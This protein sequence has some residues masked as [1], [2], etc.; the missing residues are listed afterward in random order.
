MLIART[1]GRLESATDLRERGVW[2]ISD[3]E[4]HVAIRLKQ[5]FPKVP[6]HSAGPFDLPRDNVTAADLWWFTQRYPLAVTDEDWALIEAGRDAYNQIQ[7]ELERILMP[8]YQPPAIIGLK[9]G[10]KLRPYQ[11]AAVE[12]ARA[13]KFL[14]IGDE[15]GLGKTWQAL[16]LL[17]SEPGALPAAI[18]CDPHMQIQWERVTQEITYLRAHRITQAR[19]YDLPEADVYIFRVSQ[20]MGWTDIFAQGFFKAVVF[21]EPQS[22]RTGTA[23]A[24]GS[25]AKVL[26]DHAAYR[27]GLTATPI[28][29]YGR[30]MWHVLQFIDES[31][32]GDWDDFNREWCDVTGR[33]R[34]PKALG[35]YLREQYVLVRRLKSDVGLQLPQVSRIVEPIDYDAKA[36]KSVE[37]LAARLAIKAT[38]G[39][40]LERGQAVRELD[41]LARQATGIAKAK[42]VA[43]FVRILVETGESVL[44]VGWHR[45][46]YDIWLEELK[47]LAPAMYTGS[48]SASQKNNELQRFLDGETPVLIMSLR[49]GAGVDGLQHRCSVVVFGE[50]DWSPGVHQQVIWR[51]DRDGQTK[52]VMA[53]F[54]VSDDG[55]DPPMMEVNGVKA[56]EAKQIIDPHLGVTVAPDAGNAMKKLIET[57]LEKARAKGVA[58]PAPEPEPPAARLA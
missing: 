47:D 48:E 2:R 18:V 40:F 27:L 1:Y 44:L 3:L 7:A 12:L 49:S 58:L 45:A 54:L 31:V 56:S 55:S 11:H 14:L 22:L 46:V 29:N 20:L 34:D 15:G 37:D 26:S 39:S 43:N 57:Y 53:F 25:A 30:E 52:P 24:K 13:R 6:K 19:P 32:L 51:I 35:T 4:P 50:L 5:L 41:L 28:Y 38:T 17:A 23:T 16:G 36:V 10:F 9:E 8:D 33:I 42:A 21:D